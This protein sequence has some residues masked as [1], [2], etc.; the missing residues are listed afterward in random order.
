MQCHRHFL[1]ENNVFLKTLG[2][3]H[4]LATVLW[5]QIVFIFTGPVGWSQLFS[6]H[7]PVECNQHPYTHS[8]A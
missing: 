4:A 3:N 6:F 7:R 2:K 5:G 8:L 1:M